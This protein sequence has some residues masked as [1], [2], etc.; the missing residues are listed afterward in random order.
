[1]GILL[2]IPLVAFSSVAVDRSNC[3][4]PSVDWVIL[5]IYVALG[6]LEVCKEVSLKGFGSSFGMLT[7]SA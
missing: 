7:Y 4:V 5:K 3:G 2:F 1:M 6:W